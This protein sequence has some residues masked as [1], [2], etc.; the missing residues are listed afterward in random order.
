MLPFGTLLEEPW[1]VWRFHLWYMHVAKLG[2]K[3]FISRVPKEY[4]HF[5]DDCYFSIVFHNMHRLL[6]RKE[7]N[8]TQ[9][10]LFA[11]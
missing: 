8:V 1:E 4:L 9:L 7:L 10:T 3:E 6:R 5:E 2:M 11:M